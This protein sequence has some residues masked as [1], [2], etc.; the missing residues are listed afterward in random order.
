MPSLPPSLTSA[1]LVSSGMLV[2]K[3]T[4]PHQ[5]L[6][7]NS[8]SKISKTEAST[9]EA[10]STIALLCLWIIVTSQIVHPPSFWVFEQFISIGYFFELLFGPGVLFIAIGM[11]FSRPFFESL[12]N[13]IFSC[14][15]PNPQNFVGVG[16]LTRDFRY[17]SEQKSD[18]QQE[19][20]HALLMYV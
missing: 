7:I 6:D 18:K 19:N 17:Q 14:V 10:S 4:L 9:G 11:V 12:P 5:I 2:L 1:S 13:F 20:S 15:L 8:S 3:E 16:H